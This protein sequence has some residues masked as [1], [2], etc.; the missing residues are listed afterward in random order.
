MREEMGMAH[1]LVANVNLEGRDFEQ[2]ERILNEQVIP[3]VRQAP[4]FQSGVWLRMPDGKV[5]M[6]VIVF[7]SE[8]N[9]KAAE[10]AM[11]SMRPPDAPPMT[12]ITV[13]E[14]TAQA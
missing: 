6:A 9:A 13:C 7:D 8:A 2:V 12:S 4:G 11:P 3:G 14:V 10:Q 1:A 5:G